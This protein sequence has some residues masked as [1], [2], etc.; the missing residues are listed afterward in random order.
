MNYINNKKLKPLVLAM[1]GVSNLG[2]NFVMAE[3][4]S[5]E[6]ESI[7]VITVT[8]QKKSESI[9]D[10]PIA[11]TAFD[12]VLLDAKQ[13]ASVADVRYSAPNVSYSKDNFIASNF[14]IRG[15]GADV[16]AAASDTGVGVHING[17]PLQQ[18]RLFQTEYYDIEAL[19]ILRGPQGTLFGRNST[20][21]SVNMR[22]KPANSDA[23]EAHLETEFGNF[24]HRKFKGAVNVP[25]GD[26]FAM[27]IAGI[28]L[29]REGYSE[30]IFTGNDIDG[31]D[32]WSTRI[33]FNWQPSDNT[34]INLVTSLMEEDSTRTRSQKQLCH[35]DPSGL[36]GCLPDQLDFG[37]VNPL[38]QITGTLPA[39]LGPLAPELAVSN[40]GVVANPTD[41]RKVAAD[42]DPIY[43]MDETLVMLTI[44]HQ[45]DQYAWSTKSSYHE[46]SLISQQ[47]FNMNANA[48][49][50]QPS[51]LLPIVAPNTFATY[52]SDGLFPNSAR[53][54]NNTGVVG[55]NIAY[56]GQT[57]DAIDQS[58]NDVEEFSFETY[59]SSDYEGNFNFLLGAFYLEATL[60][61]DYWVS[62]TGLDYFSLVFPAAIGADGLGWVSPNFRNQTNEY[63]LETSALFGETYFELQ[64]DLKLTIGARYTRDEKT[65]DDIGNLFVRTSDGVPVL[66]PFGSDIDWSDS[67]PSRKDSASWSEWTGRVVVDW[68]PDV[69]FTD[70]T[71]V[72]GSISRGYKG[73][74]FNPAVS[75]D[76]TLSYNP[77]FSPEYVDSFEVGTKN[78]M[79]EQTLQLNMTAFYY[80]YSDLQ[81]SKIID[82]TSFNENTDAEIYGLE[83]ELVYVPNDNW[84]FDAN[85]AYLKTEVKNF[86]S[87]DPRD[88]IQ[89][90]DDVTLIK[91][92]E[93]ASNCI[94][95]HNGA[96][97]PAMSQFNSCVNPTL[98]DGSPLPAPYTLATGIEVDLSGNSLP[99]SPELTA[100]LGAQYTHELISADLI[101]R[102]DYYWQDEMYGRIYNREPI[103]KIDSWGIWNAQVTLHSHEDTWYAR[104][105]VKNGGDKDHVVGMYV[106]DA[107]AG[108]FTNTFLVDPRLVGL[109]FG[110]KF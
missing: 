52:F 41:M 58:N 39:L 50:Y 68:S 37:N 42:F 73:G 36:L 71:L 53:V 33:S 65:I 38:A 69:S 19:E 12:E 34:D 30:N 70:D 1:L 60:A 10:V 105:Y 84:R 100:N 109:T 45:F 32:Q 78:L 79:W 23:F 66:L 96:S 8:A 85:I 35:T 81:V 107:S 76:Q 49:F 56:Y 93:S 74:G 18:P 99:N 55:G 43:K 40:G 25:L 87:V 98:L 54:E 59:V 26:T 24:D 17:I 97:A 14:K 5:D 86:S 75:D 16:I 22:I 104:A 103:D 20:G 28:F 11:V 108:L 88:P 4:N 102:L 92:L 21:G 82:Q 13:I 3:E 63:Q 67:N 7:N 106:A 31:R 90:R 6:Q 2:A 62:A 48:D 51:S 9:Q 101:F 89:G 61:D 15:V 72:Y 29:E 95:I 83:T 44:E 91:D 27:R 57:L 47:D 80:D 110:Y 77:Y 64:E 46:T 94:V